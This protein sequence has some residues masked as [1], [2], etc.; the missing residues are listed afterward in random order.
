M[1]PSRMVVRKAEK[2]DIEAIVQITKDNE[3]F[4]SPAVDGDEALTRVIGREDN[5]ILVSVDAATDND[6][7]KITGFLIGTWDGARAFIHKLSVR[8]DVQKEGIGTAL[9][10]AAIAELKSMGEIGR[11]SCRERV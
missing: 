7:E 10:N 9:V 4:W 1:A 2:A 8:P 5:V 11:A 3:H 6:K